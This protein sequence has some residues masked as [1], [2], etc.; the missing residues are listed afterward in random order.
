MMRTNLFV[1]AVAAGVA[2][3]AHATMAIIPPASVPGIGLFGVVAT[4]VA[5]A[6]IAWWRM[7]K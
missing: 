2:M 7:R 1:I 4:G 5:A 6:F 3:P